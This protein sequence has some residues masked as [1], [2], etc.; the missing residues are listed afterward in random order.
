[1]MTCFSTVPYSAIPSVRGMRHSWINHCLY[2]SRRFGQVSDA[3][4]TRIIVL[5]PF[6]MQYRA[7]TWLAIIPYLN[8]P[9]KGCFKIF[10]HQSWI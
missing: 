5:S 3:A 8:C 6:K 4:V 7:T 9:V 1:M 2:S 10:V